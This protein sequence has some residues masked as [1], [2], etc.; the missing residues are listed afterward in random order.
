VP[1][2]A[3]AR[4]RASAAVLPSGLDPLP[5]ESLAG[6]LLRLS[7]RLECSLA[8]ILELA[9]FAGARGR[10]HVSDP[11]TTQCFS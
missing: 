1:P 5:D 8:R 11:L 3:E 7:H 10:Q 2:R 9:G 4:V 6:F